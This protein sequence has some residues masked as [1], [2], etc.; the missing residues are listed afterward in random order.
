MPE[1][2]SEVAVSEAAEPVLPEFRERRREVRSECSPIPAR[3][4]TDSSVMPARVLDISKSGI[5][6]EVAVCLAV[7]SEAT[8]Y[9]NNIVA[10]GEIRFCRRNQNASFDAGMAVQDVIS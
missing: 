3:V 5:R 2:A 4:Q 10:T 7:P 1:R 9:F 8:V 6:L